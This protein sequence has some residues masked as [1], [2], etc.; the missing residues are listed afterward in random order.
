M[1][2]IV[3]AIGNKY[4]YNIAKMSFKSSEYSGSL[5]TNMNGGD[6]KV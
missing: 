1:H 2:N 4:T 6:I 5:T 3:S